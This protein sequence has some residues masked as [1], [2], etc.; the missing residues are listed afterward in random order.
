MWSFRARN[1]IAFI[2]TFSVSMIGT[3]TAKA[4]EWKQYR[5]ADGAG[6]SAEKLEA[7]RKFGAESGSAAVFIVERGNVVAAWGA[8]DHPFKAASMRKSVYDAVI[9][10]SQK[11]KRFDP[12]RTISELG[13]DDLQPLTDEEKK[14]TVEHLMT[15][16]SGIYHP[17]AYET[18]SNA[19]R[20]PDRGSHAVG[21]FWYY[22]NW[23]FNLVTEAFER[24]NGSAIDSA[25]EKYL[26]GPLGLEDYEREHVF[27]WLEPRSSKYPAVTYRLSARDLAR[28]GQMY[29]DMGKWNGKQIVPAAWVRESTRPHTVFGKDHY[30][31]EGNGY[32]RLWWI[33]PA[34]ENT[35]SK[36]L[37]YHRIAAQGA[38]GQVMVLF[39]EIDLLI[40]HLAD[41][42]SG[43]G[44]D[45]RDGFKLME[46]IL[47]ARTG[48]A[49]GGERIGPVRVEP[50]SD[51]EPAPLKSGLKAVPPALQKKLEGRFTVNERIGIEFY[52][53]EDRLFAAP[54]GM[55]LPDAEMLLD[56]DGTL[57]SPLVE[58]VF[59]PLVAADGS[60]N[61]VKMTFGGRTSV[62]K[63]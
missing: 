43:N 20:R 1:L 44:V 13:I 63:R 30:R 27:R 51:K 45:D 32:G 16:T 26:A 37:S 50:L 34:R 3:G 49:K 41:T 62:G 5:D 6:W 36:Y 21:E 19:E 7:A 61:E 31:G 9:G 46:M 28:I 29:L 52:R 47:E 55:P 22:N 60:V 17:A 23:D 8:V 33:W 53:Y 15:A 54:V 11:D 58:V 48:G 4:Q 35:G 59:E 39:P 10:A 18:R 38:G 24:M 56:G 25:F 2:V 42:D 40:V 12:S 14:A 57:T